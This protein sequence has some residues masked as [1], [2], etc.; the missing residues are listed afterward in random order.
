MTTQTKK[1]TTRKPR[2]K[3]TVAVEAPPAINSLPKLPFVFEVLDLTSKQV[4]NANKVK[5]LQAHEFDA[6]KSILKWNFDNTIVSLLPPGE[7]PY[8]DAEDQDMYSGSLSENIAREAA[9]G[10]SAT[11][12]DLDGRGKTSLRREWANLYHFV[13]GGNDSMKNLR[14]ES[15][16][17]NLLSGL[18]P[19][20]AEIMCLVKEKSL[21]D[22]YKITRS[23][24]EEAYPDIEW[25]DKA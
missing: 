16:F 10:E 25:R 6:L 18:H 20:E 15:M 8:G 13:K 4:G 14:R 19:L 1:T 21:E 22:K 17:I 23:I 5:A 9:G 7:V 3:K 12:Q 24:V 2:A 11:G